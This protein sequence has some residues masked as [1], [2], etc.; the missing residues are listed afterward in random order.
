MALVD[1]IDAS[2]AAAV[3]RGALD[4]GI[5][6]Y[7]L[8]LNTWG[9]I[10]NR[11]GLFSAY[12][13]FLRIVAAPGSVDPVLKDASA[14]LVGHLNGCRYTVTHRFAS[15]TRNG[16]SE[17][18]LADVVDGNWSGLLPPWR[19]V[20]EL[21]RVMTALPTMIPYSV[22]SQLAEPDLLAEVRQD[23]TAEQLVELTMSISVWNALS[24]FHRLMGFDLDMP[25]APE[26][27]EPR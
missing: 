2:R 4:S 18:M 11:P 9:A 25:H 1:L 17:Q 6:Q 24:R 16:A 15:A 23:W 12:L 7:G 14:L 21:T 20:L 27:I 26:G 13:P 5:E 8:V 19:R 10:L 22:Q 3:D